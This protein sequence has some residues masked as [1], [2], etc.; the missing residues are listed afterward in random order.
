MVKKGEYML[1]DSIYET[2]MTFINKDGFHIAKYSDYKNNENSLTFG[3]FKIK[4]K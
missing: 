1:P 3:V 4:Q 2:A